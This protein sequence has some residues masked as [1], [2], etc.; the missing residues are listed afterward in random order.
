MDFVN[1]LRAARCVQKL[2]ASTPPSPEETAAVTRQLRELGAG[3][4]RPL[5]DSLGHGV[6]RGPALQVLE[7]LLDDDTLPLFVEALTS[8]NPAVVSGICHV[9]ARSRGYQAFPLVDLLA[10]PALPKAA[11]EAVLLEKADE[12]PSRRLVEAVPDLPRDS[13]TVVFRLLDKCVD[14]SALGSMLSLLGHDDWSVRLYM[15]RLLGRFPQIEVKK[16]LAGLLQDANKE[17]RRQAVSSLH[18]VKATEAIPD[19]VRTLRDGDLKVQSAAIDAIS[20]LGDASSVTDLLDV[21]KDESEY[22]RRAA[23][24]VLNE[25]ATAEAIQDLLRALR[26]E[27]WWVRVRAADA[28][29]TLGGDH[30]V[31][32]V[33]GLLDDDD[34]FIRRYAVEILNAVPSEK[35]VGPLVHALDDPDWWVRERS[36]DALAKTGDVRVVGPLIALMERD[37]GVTALCARALGE[38]KRPEGI[39]PL[40][41]IARTGDEDARRE[42]AAALKAI[43]LRKLSPEQRDLVQAALKDAPVPAPGAD[44]DQPLRVNPA[45][46]PLDLESLRT[47]AATGRPVAAA[48]ED[49]GSGAPGSLNAGDGSG[50]PHSDAPATAP[51]PAALNYH[52]LVQGT[53]LLDRY[54]VLRRVGQGG[55]SAVYLVRD[56]V[57]Q[58]E[59]IL[60][61]L[62]PQLSA[63]EVGLLRFVQELKVTRRLSHPNIIRLYDFLDLGGAHAVSMEYFRGQDLGCIIDEEAPLPVLRALRIASRIC[64]G[65]AAAHAAGVVHRDVKPANVLIGP[66]D[67]LKICDFGLASGGPQTGTRLTKSG[68]LIGTPE[69]MAP[70]QISGE[71]LDHRADIYSVGILLYEMLAG[72]LPYAAE[73]P[74]KVLFQHLEAEAV[75]IEKR[76]SGLP[77]EIAALV[78]R[79][80]ARERRHR[81][82]DANELKA[83]LEE[84]VAAVAAA[85]PEA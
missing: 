55:F 7:S 29:G 70:E 38:L 18:Q 65:L 28:L 82:A 20:N 36:I 54:T 66:H 2:K 62:N 76:V 24:E 6:A 77:E 19:L 64:D 84:A 60:K 44:G 52:K 80:M 37:P 8:T 13:R 85:Q 16:G 34:D 56:E 10:D 46:R 43:D 40:C 25:I 41:R 3:A 57:V 35:A 59:M 74:V 1:R 51:G 17:V 48:G 79:T 33:I 30:V 75:P 23:V 69:Y 9:L 50:T 11:L 12:I 15:A 26:D 32:A 4:V 67:A 63:D 71:G 58:E 21:L 68:Y 27:D 61:I 39:D 49:N 83:S 72:V 53:T 73:T 31:Q 45:H 47:D 42:A 78:R 81:P 14:E 5:I 22:A